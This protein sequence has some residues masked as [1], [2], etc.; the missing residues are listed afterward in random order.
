[1][2]FLAIFFVGS[3][4]LFAETINALAAIVEGEPITLLDISKVMAEKNAS[5]GQALDFLID[6]RLRDAKVKELGIDAD[7]GEINSRIALIAKRNDLDAASLRDV[8]TR[9]GVN[10]TNY[11]EQVKTAII[12]EK[13]SNAIAARAAIPISE[14]EIAAFYDRNSAKFAVPSE[15]VV[16]QYAAKDERAL[17]AAQQNP[18]AVDPNVAATTQTLKS[19]ELNPRLL[20]LLMNTEIGGFTPIFPAADRLVTLLVREKNGAETRKLEDVKGLIADE[21]RAINEERVIA[22]YFAKARSAARIEIVREE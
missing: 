11:L 22:G 8:L 10:W 2:R 5:R 12:N 17:A 1:M 20:A 21:L 4:L 18:L 16:I 6:V 7:E 3:A 15:I 19:A 14:G 13:L 9:R